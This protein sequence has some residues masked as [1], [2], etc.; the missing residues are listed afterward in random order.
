MKKLSIIILGCLFTTNFLF[1]Q[2]I[3]GVIK[4]RTKLV[5][6]ETNKYDLVSYLY[7]NA[8]TSLFVYD[9]K[10]DME[11]KDS[12]ESNVVSVSYGGETIGGSSYPAPR[13]R[14]EHGRMYL[15]DNQTQTLKIREF[16]FRKVYITEEKIPA[17][18]WTIV[19]ERKK[20]GKFNCQK[21]TTSFRGREYEAWFCSDIPLSIGPWK[22]QGLP[23][24]ILEARSKDGIVAFELEKVEIPKDVQTQLNLTT[25]PSGQTVSFEEFKM[26]PEKEAKKAAMEHEAMLKAM[27]SKY[28]EDNTKVE[29]QK[30]FSIELTYE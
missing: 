1:A 21:A 4:Y 6:Y 5:Q 20:I 25:L 29:I 15:K 18:K 27:D 8:Q 11:A 9:R 22:L 3:S 12:L 19:S 24:A 14:D 16:I 13:K 2:N 7:F 28:N 10:K 30:P 26:L 23:G 17:I